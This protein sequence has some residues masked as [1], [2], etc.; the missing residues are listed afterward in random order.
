MA[1][2]N[3]IAIHFNVSAS[4]VTRVINND[5][6]ISVTMETFNRILEAVE[7]LDYK[8]VRARKS[9]QNKKM[10]KVNAMPVVGARKYIV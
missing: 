1:T 4:T 3:D 6:I 8:T 10:L 7:G 9:Q 2:I 5:Q